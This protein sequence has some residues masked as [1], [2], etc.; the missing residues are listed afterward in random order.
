ML[1]VLPSLTAK[2]SHRRSILGWSL[3]CCAVEL[4]VVG[5]RWGRCDRVDDGDGDDDN[6]NI[7]NEFTRIIAIIFLVFQS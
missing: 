6:Y 7:S 3:S 2:L 5:G 1:S 4:V